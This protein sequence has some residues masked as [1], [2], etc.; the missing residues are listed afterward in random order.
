VGIVAG[1]I[2][3]E[4]GSGTYSSYDAMHRSAAAAECPDLVAL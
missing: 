2:K 3:G 1:M 4:H